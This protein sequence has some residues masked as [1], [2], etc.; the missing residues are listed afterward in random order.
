MVESFDSSILDKRWVKVIRI[1]SWA[2]AFVAGCWA[3]FIWAE[4]MTILEIVELALQLEYFFFEGLE[5]DRFA[6]F[7]N[8]IYYELQSMLT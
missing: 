7:I 4:R 1:E 3:R 8:K 5:D 2:D 6:H